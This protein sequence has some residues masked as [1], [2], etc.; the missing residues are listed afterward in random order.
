VTYLQKQ[1]IPPQNID[2]VL[3]APKVPVSPFATNFLDGS[4]INIVM[5]CIQDIQ[6]RQRK[7]L[8]LSG[9]Q[10]VQMPF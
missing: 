3:V 1:V 8:K 2:V 5:P 4:G 6:V 7:K 9:S 10:S